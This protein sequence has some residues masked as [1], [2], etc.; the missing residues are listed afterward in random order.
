MAVPALLFVAVNQGTDGVNG[1]GIPMATDIAFAVSVLVALGPRV[2]RAL[3]LFLLTLAIA[4]D[5]GAILVIALFYSKGVQPGWLLAGAGVVL[6]IIVLRRLG[7]A[8]PLAYVLPG[9]VLWFCLLESGVHATIAGVVLGLLTPAGK[10][11]GRYVIEQLEHWLHPWTSLLIVPVFALAS[12]GVVLDVESLERA[13]S[14]TVTWGVILGLVIGKPLGIL[15]ATL[16]GV[17]TGFVRLPSTIGIAHVAG[18][19]AVAGIGF[20]VS[21]FIADLSFTGALVSDAKIGILVASLT[22]AIVGAVALASMAR[23][24]QY[25][26][27]LPTAGGGVS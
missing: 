12:A 15:L 8:S 3:K 21:L 24:R 25:A 9:V 19:G 27:A 22:S 2:P 20:T 10:V 1:W 23:R 11:R 4:D 16:V 14:G 18:A 6:A 13:F 17:R 26:E 7:A 5:V